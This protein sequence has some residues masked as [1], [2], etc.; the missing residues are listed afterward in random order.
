MAFDSALIC[1]VSC[2]NPAYIG[3][4]HTLRVWEMLWMRLDG[5]GI[6]GRDITDGHADSYAC[7]PEP[8]A[9]SH[10]NWWC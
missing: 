7:F 10:W 2:L 8:V 6:K 4:L 3:F 1:W 9:V 5:T